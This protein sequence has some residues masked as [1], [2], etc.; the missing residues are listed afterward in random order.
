MGCCNVKA[1]SP[2]PNG[3]E[4]SADSH[5]RRKVVS[6]ATTI[7][8]SHPPM[9][10][11]GIVQPNRQPSATKEWSTFKWAQDQPTGPPPRYRMESEEISI[12][13]HDASPADNRLRGSESTMASGCLLFSS[14]AGSLLERSSV[15]REQFRRIAVSTADARSSQQS[16]NRLADERSDTTTM[17]KTAYFTVASKF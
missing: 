6:R 4:G 17:D 5:I 8:P 7:K 9:E 15:T 12:H 2:V 3:Q 11:R 13:P 16:C 10:C 1:S 14:Q